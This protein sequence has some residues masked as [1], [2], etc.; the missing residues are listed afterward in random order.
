MTDSSAVAG[1]G[2]PRLATRNPMETFAEVGWAPFR[3]EVG[4]RV[5]E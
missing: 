4:K 2:M 5:D 1:S 3:I